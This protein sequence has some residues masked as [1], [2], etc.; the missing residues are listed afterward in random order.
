MK[1]ILVTVIVPCYNVEKYIEKGLNSLI[2]QT[3]KDI[4]IIVIN[5]GSNDNTLKILNEFKKNDKRIRII[6]KK[7]EGV[8][9]ARN[10]GLKEAKGK[11]ICFMDS[12]DWLEKDFL[13]K[14]YNKISENDYDMVACDTYAIYPNKKKYIKSN[15][16]D[17]QDEKKLMIDA[18]TVIWNKIYKKEIIKDI[19]F[20]NSISFC[21][22]VLFLYEVYLKVKR[23]GSIHEPLYN[24][25]Q[26]EKSLTYTYNEIIYDLIKSIDKVVDYYEINNYLDKYYQEIEYSYVRYLF[27]TFIKRLSKTKNKIEFKKGCNF[28]KNKVKEKFPYYK[29][30]KYLKNKKGLYL[31]YFNNVFASII[32]YLEKNKM[33]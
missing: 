32:F 17:N 2:N 11:Y 23:V 31:K 3:L 16:N 29:K 1:E 28:V 19:Y 18:Y 21:E 4:E 10:I 27:A 14:M 33:N 9:A 5:D 15:I 30:N 7:N 24:Y 6:D 20:D 22:D 12:D 13:E 8:S 26:R 25:L